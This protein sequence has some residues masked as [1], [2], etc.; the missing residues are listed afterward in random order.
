MAPSTLTLLDPVRHVADN[1][2]CWFRGV[3]AGKWVAQYRASGD[4]GDEDLLGA[5]PV[6]PSRA[7]VEARAVMGG[8]SLDGLTATE[9]GK[10][11]MLLRWVVAKMI[12]ECARHW[13]CVGGHADLRRERLDGVVGERVWAR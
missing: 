12:E 2:R 8:R 1:E 10:G 11:R 3:V 6:G 13:C 5:H 7:V 4:G 9:L